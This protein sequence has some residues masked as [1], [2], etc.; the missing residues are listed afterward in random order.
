MVD[1]PE[2]ENARSERRDRIIDKAREL[3]RMLGQTSEYEYLQA[4]N[5]DIADD[6]D[7][8][9]L[10]NRFKELQ[11]EAVEHL[12]RGEDPP[13][14]V[15]DELEEVRG[16]LQGS[17]RYQSLVAAQSN[18]DKLMQKVQNAIGEGMKKGSESQIVMPS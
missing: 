18:F 2:Q 11:E 9:E 14:E 6:R 4:A 1:Q 8:T 12:E 10:I 5:E 13:E 3:G 17:P 15:Q 16:E 7:A